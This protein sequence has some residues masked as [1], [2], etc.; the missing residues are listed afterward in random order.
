M[1]VCIQH[2]RQPR[3]TKPIKKRGLTALKMRILRVK[4]AH[5]TRFYAQKAHILTMS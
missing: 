4:R 1:S 5:F 3:Q 2:D